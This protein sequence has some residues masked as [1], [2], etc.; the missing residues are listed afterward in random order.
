MP[1]SFSFAP[2]SFSFLRFDLIRIGCQDGNSARD[3]AGKCYRGDKVSCIRLFDGA[4]AASADGA[5]AVAVAALV[6][7]PPRRPF[8]PL[9]LA[10]IAAQLRPMERARLSAFA[11]SARAAFAAFAHG[12]RVHMSVVA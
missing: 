9:S 7:R 10:A 3:L 11:L 5:S 6:D 1:I 8:A 2:L 4:I 12:P